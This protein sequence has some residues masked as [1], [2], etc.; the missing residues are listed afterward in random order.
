MEKL[1][2][3][4]HFHTAHRQPGYPGHC[5]HVHGHTWR[6]KVTLS[7]EEFPRDELDMSVDFGE[8]K[9]LVR[10]LDH[11]IIVTKDDKTFLDPKVFDQEGVFVVEGRGPSVENV[12]RYICNKVVDLLKTKYP[13]RGITY[14]L[15]VKLQETDNN[16][17]IIGKSVTV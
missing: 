1:I 11:K 3:K 7:C 14:D 17:F 13:A 15:E 9:Q 2:V 5:Q 4:A 16:I 8:I 12:A 10:F 6:A